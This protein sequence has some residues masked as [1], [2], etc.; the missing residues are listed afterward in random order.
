MGPLDPKA[1]FYLRS[2][3]VGESEA[4]RLLTY[5]FGAEILGRMQ[6]PALRAQLDS[7]VRARLA[8]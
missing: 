6:V 5:G 1:L 8:E 7:I 4:R 2:R 3:G